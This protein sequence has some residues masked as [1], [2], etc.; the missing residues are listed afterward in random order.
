QPFDAGKLELSGDAVP[1]GEGFPRG[2]YSVF[3]VSTTGVLTY[4]AG[5]L[6]GGT[7][8]LTWFDRGGKSLGVAGDPGEYNTVSLSP[9]GSRVALDRIDG[10]NDDI[11]LH[12]FGRGITSRL[13]S[14]PAQD[15]LPVWSPDGQHIIFSSAHGG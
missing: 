2:D 7:R 13:T 11:W 3:A 9:D 10:G 14:D 1:L 12:E 15:W 5:A 8:Q 4:R 6:A